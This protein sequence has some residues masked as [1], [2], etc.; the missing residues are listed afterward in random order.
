MQQL[1]WI[2]Q[3]GLQCNQQCSYKRETEEDLTA[4]KGTE[5]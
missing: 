4:E 3:M 1:P 2:I 5:M